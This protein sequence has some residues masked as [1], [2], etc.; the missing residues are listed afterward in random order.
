[1]EVEKKLTDLTINVTN[2]VSDGISSEKIKLFD[3]NLEPT[4]SNLDHGTES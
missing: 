4:M 1:M 2:W 3:T